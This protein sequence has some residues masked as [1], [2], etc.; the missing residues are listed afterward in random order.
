MAAALNGA[1]GEIKPPCGCWPSIEAV[2]AGLFPLISVFMRA[3]RFSTGIVHVPQLD[4]KIIYES[5]C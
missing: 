2:V 5:V 1:A 4:I 3:L